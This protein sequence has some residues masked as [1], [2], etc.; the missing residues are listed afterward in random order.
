MCRDDDLYTGC[1]GDLTER[2]GRHERGE[3]PATASR[4]PL[5][6]VWHCV[7]PDKYVTFRFERYLK[8]GSGRAFLW[9]HIL[10]RR[11]GKYEALSGT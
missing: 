5:R 10:E 2:L 8:Q 4:L 6:L 11:K 9:K 3:V 7:F 1:T